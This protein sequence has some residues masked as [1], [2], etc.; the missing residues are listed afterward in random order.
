LA[1]GVPYNLFWHLTP[2][3]LRSFMIAFEQQR[4]YQDAQLWYMGQYVVSALNATV[5]NVFRKEN[6][7]KQ[8][9]IEKP[10]QHKSE[11]SESKQLTE[12]EIIRQTQALFAQLEVKSINEKRQ[13]RLAEKNSKVE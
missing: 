9:Y 5:M 10:I 1:I 6:A 11:V 12:E 2:N 4:E 7:E 13:K 3:K 8:T